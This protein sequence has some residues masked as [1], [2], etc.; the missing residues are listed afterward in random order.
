MHPSPPGSQQVSA[1]RVNT[2]PQGCSSAA[3]VAT[4]AMSLPIMNHLEKNGA[5]SSPKITDSDPNSILMMQQHIHNQSRSRKPFNLDFD[6]ANRLNAT[7]NS[8]AMNASQFGALSKSP[9]TL[10]N[11][12]PSAHSVMLN[13][14][15]LIMQQQFQDSF[16]DLDSVEVINMSQ[17]N[18]TKSKHNF[19]Q[20]K[21]QQQQQ[22][23]LAILSDNK[24]S[25][26]KSNLKS[27]LKANGMPGQFTASSMNDMA[28]MMNNENQMPAQFQQPVSILK[29]FDSSEKMYP[30]SR[31]GSGNNNALCSASL[32]NFGMSNPSHMGMNKLNKYSHNFKS[33]TNQKIHFEGSLPRRNNRYAL[34]QSINQGP[35]DYIDQVVVNGQSQLYEDHHPIHQQSQH[36]HHH[37]HQ[38]SM[39]RSFNQQQ[40][41]QMPQSMQPVRKRV[42]FANIPPLASASSAGDLTL[43]GGQLNPAHHHHSGHHRHRSSSKSHGHHH[44]H[45]HGGHHRHHRRSSSTSNFNTST[46]SARPASSRKH[47]HH[48]SHHHKRQLS[49]RSLTMAPTNSGQIYS[50][51]DYCY[52]THGADDYDYNDGFNSACEFDDYYNNTCSTCSSSTTSSSNTTTSTD[53]DEEDSDLD[54]DF[55]MYGSQNKFYAQ[56]MRPHGGMTQFD[57]RSLNRLNL[58]NTGNFAQQQQQQQRKFTNPSTGLKISYVDNLPLARTNPVP[59]GG[60]AGTKQPKSKTS[61]KGLNK[62]KKDNCVVS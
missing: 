54:D 31:P 49:N 24:P 60:Q 46:M 42:Q 1:T 61:K 56:H 41:L 36:H 30:I 14:K 16:D 4:Q 29:K 13:K 59:N 50:D 6:A 23:P 48:H 26:L 53:S 35:I 22:Q 21:Q 20:Q 47:S 3:S 2:P 55:G 11:Q 17:C 52:Q 43:T 8:S 28:D 34:S 10:S 19:M 33:L 40:Q 5:L 62:F 18:V 25:N 15:N 39:S 7:V 37:S 27:S 32:N 38:H 12:Q 45:H 51:S 44:H 9:L 57:Q 58:N